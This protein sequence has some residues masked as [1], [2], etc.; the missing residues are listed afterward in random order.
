MLVSGLTRCS[1]INIAKNAEAYR[2]GEHSGYEETAW[3]G[4]R[5]TIGVLDEKRIKV[6]I[7]GGALNPKGLAQRVAE[8]VSPCQSNLLVVM[9]RQPLGEREEIRPQSRIS[10]R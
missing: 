9:Y 6:A 4:L 1:E 7:N 5:M 10:V 8:L 3:E 2:A